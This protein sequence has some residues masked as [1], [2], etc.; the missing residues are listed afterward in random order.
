MFFVMKKLKLRTLSSDFRRFA[1]DEASAG[2]GILSTSGIEP[3]GSTPHKMYVLAL[4]K[5]AFA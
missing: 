1:S 3:T 5:N 4:G 2:R